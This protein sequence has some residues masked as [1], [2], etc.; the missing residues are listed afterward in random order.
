M[1]KFIIKYTISE[2]MLLNNVTIYKDSLLII[3]VVNDF[4]K[5]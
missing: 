3:K 1:S 4:S 2:I 5:L